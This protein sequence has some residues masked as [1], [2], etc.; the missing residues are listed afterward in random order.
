MEER[1]YTLRQACGLLG[2][3]VRTA[4]EWLKDGRLRGVKYQQSNRWFVPESEIRRIK[5][6]DNTK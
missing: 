1:Y 5:Y 3:K 2:I 6:G 4:R